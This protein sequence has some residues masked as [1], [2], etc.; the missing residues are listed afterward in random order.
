NGINI[1]SSNRCQA[2]GNSATGATMLYAIVLGAGSFN[3]AHINEARST[4]GATAVNIS[5]GTGNV[6]SLNIKS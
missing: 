5:G 6:E 4:T 2:I 3:M 1:S